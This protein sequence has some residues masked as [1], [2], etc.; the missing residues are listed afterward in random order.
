MRKYTNPAEI[1]QI[2]LS[3]LIEKIEVYHIEK[4]DGQKVQRLNIYYNCVGEIVIPEFADIPIT[5]TSMNTRQ[6]VNVTYF[7]KSA[8]AV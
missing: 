2:M 6:G 3:E 1:T 7:P 4:I 5:E 8:K